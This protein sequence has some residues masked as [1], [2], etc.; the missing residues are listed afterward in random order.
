M[1]RLSSKLNWNLFYSPQGVQLP[2]QTLVPLYKIDIVV[3]II[4]FWFLSRFFFFCLHPLV[5]EILTVRQK[6]WGIRWFVPQWGGGNG[7]IHIPIFDLRSRIRLRPHPLGLD[8][9]PQHR[10][11]AISVEFMSTA[12]YRSNKGSFTLFSGGG[13]PIIKYTNDIQYICVGR[14]KEQRSLFYTNGASLSSNVNTMMHMEAINVTWPWKAIVAVTLTIK[15]HISLEHICNH[16]VITLIQ[17]I[18]IA[19]KCSHAHCI[20]DEFFM[21]FLSLTFFILMTVSGSY[22]IHYL[23]SSYVDMKNAII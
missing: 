16:D 20:F 14:M 19:S 2:L 4:W 15:V 7:P 3:P 10:V 5:S 9:W 21:C 23:E 17:V 12:Y 11:S 22:I 8:R 1:I 6:G 13:W 18:I